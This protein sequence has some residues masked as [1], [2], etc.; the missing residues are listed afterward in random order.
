M[1]VYEHLYQHTLCKMKRVKWPNWKGIFGEKSEQYNHW[2]DNTFQKASSITLEDNF[3]TRPQIPLT[4]ES[5][6]MKE[7]SDALD[8]VP[9]DTYYSEQQSKFSSS[10]S[11]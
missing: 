5:L 11:P 3:E 4:D 8:N 6:Q 10:S 9:K 1:P 7:L 2:D